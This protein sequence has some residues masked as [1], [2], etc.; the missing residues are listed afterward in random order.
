MRWLTV[1]V[2]LVLFVAPALGQGMPQVDPY[3]DTGS[4]I[5]T[6]R[7][8][9]AEDYLDRAG[10][11][12]QRS[13]FT[14]ANFLLTDAEFELQQAIEF[15]LDPD[16]PAAVY[17]RDDIARART[18]MEE[19]G[20][21]EDEAAVA[22][23]WWNRMFEEHARLASGLL[24]RVDEEA[25]LD[26]EELYWIPPYF[27]GVISPELAEFQAKYPDRAAFV[28]L[29]PDADVTVG[30]GRSQARPEDADKD[31]FA[32]IPEIIGRANAA[33]EQ[34]VIAS[35]AELEA[36][37]REKVLAETGEGYPLDAIAARDAARVIL[38]RQPDNEMAQRIHD[39]A[40]EYLQAFWDEHRFNIED[41]VMPAD[42]APMTPTCTRPCRPPT[43]P[44][45]PSRAGMIRCCASW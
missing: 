33:M 1:L 6:D 2:T 7:M 35:L 34:Y 29:V 13:E 4:D 14:N 9:V 41:M 39:K 44:K 15:G 40:M 12:F 18:D 42:V 30:A 38:S 21:D 43:P 16:H 8:E 10:F 23:A 32:W 36:F 27:A 28:A 11:A 25:L 31:R 22:A 37:A 24:D 20:A 3:Y 17:I 45:R 26:A 19:W 5:L